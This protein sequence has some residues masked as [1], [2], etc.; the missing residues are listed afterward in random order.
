MGGAHQNVNGSRELTTF[1]S[2][3]ICRPSTS[4]CYSQ[5]AYQIWS[6]YLLP[7]R[8]YKNGYKMSKMGWF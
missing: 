6:L 7:L 5:P 1:C 4:T 3:V 8:I 2:M